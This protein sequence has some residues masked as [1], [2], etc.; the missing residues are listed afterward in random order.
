MRNPP[1]ITR[2]WL[3]IVLA[4]LL[5]AAPAWADDT[6]AIHII[7]PPGSRALDGVYDVGSLQPTFTIQVDF[8]KTDGGTEVQCQIDGPQSGPCTSRQDQC[9]VSQCWTET[10][11]FP[12]DGDGHELDV[13]VLDSNGQ[14]IDT[15]DILFAVDSTP[16]VTRFVNFDDPR[17]MSPLDFP[18]PTRAQFGF[19]TVDAD[20]SRFPNKFDCSLT[21]IGATAPGPWSPCKQDGTLPQ[22]LA[23]RGRYRFWVRAVDFL[24]RPDPAPPSYAFSPTPCQVKA[25]RPATLRGLVKRGLK[26][27]VRCV[28][29]TLWHTEL[30]LNVAQSNQFLVYPVLAAADGKNVAPGQKRVVTLRVKGRLPKALFRAHRVFVALSTSVAS[31]IAPGLKEMGLRGH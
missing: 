10:P 17:L 25:A 8:S 31:G 14:A 18:S 27:E 6:A 30:L 5:W 9:P 7:A 23:R 16:P 4:C 15:A 2:C 26:V 24:A 29:P 28:Q 1:G 19:D 3:G 13:S 21:G 11:S 12:S 22:K 20:T